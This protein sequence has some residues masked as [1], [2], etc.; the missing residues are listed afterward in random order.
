[1]VFFIIPHTVIIASFFAHFFLKDIGYVHLTDNMSRK[2]GKFLTVG[3]IQQDLEI[4]DEEH[5]VEPADA[6]FIP[7]KQLICLKMKTL[8]TVVLKMLK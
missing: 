4:L 6:V 2:R 7:Q 5:V 8:M 3:E 1:M